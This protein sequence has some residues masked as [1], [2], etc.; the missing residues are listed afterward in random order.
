MCLI[1][2]HAMKREREVLLYGRHI[3]NFPLK[4]SEWSASN[5]VCFTQVKVTPCSSK[6][7]GSMVPEQV[8]TLWRRAHTADPV[9]SQSRFLSFRALS[10]VT[11]LPELVRFR[12]LLLIRKERNSPTTTANLQDVIE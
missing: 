4:G 11:V 6:I 3:L 2:Q 5:A 8:W 10:I 1:T 12:V 9:G 7:R